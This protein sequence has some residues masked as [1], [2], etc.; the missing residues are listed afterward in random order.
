MLV[1]QRYLLA[2]ED[3][4][5]DF[6][7]DFRDLFARLQPKKERYAAVFQVDSKELRLRA[8]Q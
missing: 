7:F 1:F 4:P 5:A 2:K 8:P 6:A 3:P